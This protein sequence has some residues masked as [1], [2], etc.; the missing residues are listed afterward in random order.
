MPNKT[1]QPKQVHET[2]ILDGLQFSI[3]HAEKLLKMYDRVATRSTNNE[4]KLGAM[5]KMEAILLFKTDILKHKILLQDKYNKFLSR[6]PF[7][8][9]L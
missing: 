2:T 1:N 7:H 6:D 4:A 3:D 8:K 9:D 5:T